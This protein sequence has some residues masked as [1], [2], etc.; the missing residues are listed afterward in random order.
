MP[1]PVTYHRKIR[2]SDTDAQGIVFNANYLTYVDDALTDYFDAL[3]IPWS[4]FVER[5]YEAVVGRV[6]L[7]FRSPGRLG[8]TL[9]TGVEVGRV[10]TTSAVFEFRTWE[11][12]SQ[13]VVVEGREVYVFL[14]HTTF[15]KTPVPDWFIH[16][17]ERL[18]GSPV[19]R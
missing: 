12:G 4:E 14:D 8:D 16:A 13:Q 19:A 5:G 2:F 17:V 7:D 3:G 11:E 18:Q 1:F 15:E 9:V 10:G 6:E